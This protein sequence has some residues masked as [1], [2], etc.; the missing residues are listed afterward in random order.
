MPT[1]AFNKKK[2]STL[3][4]KEPEVPVRSHLGNNRDANTWDTTEARECK[5][6]S[7]SE[8]LRRDR[9]TG[10]DHRLDQNPLTG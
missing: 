5:A 10:Q 4:E 6:G 3:S 2:M 8:L 1:L 7:G 9:L